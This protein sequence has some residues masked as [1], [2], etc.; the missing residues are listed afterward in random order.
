MH[1]IKE[2]GR[3]G[4]VDKWRLR[5][6]GFFKGAGTAPLLEGCELRSLPVFPSGPEFSTLRRHEPLSVPPHPPAHPHDRRHLL[7][8]ANQIA[9]VAIL[10]I[11][12]TLV[13]LGAVLLDM[14][15]RRGWGGMGRLFQRSRA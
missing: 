2:R 13:I 7:N 11:G 14:W 9:V 8:V 15:K 6:V 12:M 5:R 10:A 1:G 4:P 3:P